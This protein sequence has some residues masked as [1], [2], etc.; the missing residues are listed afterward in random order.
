M[1]WRARVL[2]IGEHPALR[3]LLRLM[4]SKLALDVQEATPEQALERVDGDPPH[5]VVL[6]LHSPLDR[7]LLLCRR[8]RR[9]SRTASLPAVLLL[10]LGDEH[11]R[12]MAKAA[13][14][15]ICL[16]KPFRTRLLQET[17]QSL[18][19]THSANG[20]AAHRAHD[21]LGRIPR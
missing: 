16:D 19:S 8:L 17:V 11:L 3:R 9:N 10:P 7:A 2:V 6:D 5:L 15:T 14:A 13:G 4:L 12:A 1:D 21:G 20:G 18:L